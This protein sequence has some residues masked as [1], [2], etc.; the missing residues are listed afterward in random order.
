M[1]FPRS[2]VSDRDPRFLSHF[3]RELFALT[4]TTLR[5]LYCESSTKLTDKTER[6]NRTLEQYLK[7]SCF[8][9]ILLVGLNISLR[10]K[11]L[12]TIS[13]I[14]LSALHHFTSS[15]ND[16]R[17]FLLTFSLSDLNSKKTLLWKAYCA[18]DRLYL[19]MLVILLILRDNEWFEWIKTKTHLPPFKLDDMVLVS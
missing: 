10:L 17:T 11:S 5:F 1:D 13:H 2:I 15:T 16:T 14:L 4:E 19:L 6:T 12:T 9:I 8:D 7:T 3:W 18:L